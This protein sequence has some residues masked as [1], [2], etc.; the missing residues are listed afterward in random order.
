MGARR[1]AAGGHH[2]RTFYAASA[3]GYERLNDVG[4]T[5]EGVRAQRTKA[6]YGGGFQGEAD[7]VRVH[8]WLDELLPAI[9]EALRDAAPGTHGD[10]THP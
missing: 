5:S 7:V 2:Q 8:R 6:F 4:V 10:L 1:G 3:L 9:H